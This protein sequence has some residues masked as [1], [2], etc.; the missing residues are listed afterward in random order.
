MKSN[1]EHSW[2]HPA[3][4][5]R[6]KGWKWPLTNLDQQTNWLSYKLT[7]HIQ[8]FTLLIIHL[9]LYQFIQSSSTLLPKCG[10]TFVLYWLLYNKAPLFCGQAWY[11]NLWNFYS[12]STSFNLFHK[13]L[14]KI[15]RNQEVKPDKTPKKSFDTYTI[16]NPKKKSKNE[17]K[18]IIISWITHVIPVLADFT[19]RTTVGTKDYVFHIYCTS[20]KWLGI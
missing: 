10:N 7:K 14:D 4:Y 9:H 17:N 18:I 20:L 6:I 15:C 11:L 19:K 8:M 5:P 12:V 13:I 1:H 16:I 2:C 3:N